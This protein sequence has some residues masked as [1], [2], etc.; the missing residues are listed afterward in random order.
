MLKMR[1]KIEN[2]GMSLIEVIVSMLVLSIAV[3]TVMSAFSMASKTNLQSKRH[4]D[5]ESVMES[6]LE[7][8]EAGGTDYQ[9]AFDVA[10]TDYSVSV[11][12]AVKEETLNNIKQ[13]F[14][15]YNVTVT[16]DTAPAKYSSGEFN[17]HDVIHFGGTGH[18]TV[19]IDAS[20][21]QN[22]S[23]PHN[24][25]SDA[26]D[27]A[28]EYF[29]LWHSQAV[30]EFNEANEDVEDFVDMP[31][32]PISN[33]GSRIGRELRIMTTE[34]EPNKMQLMASFVYTIDDGVKLPDSLSR[35]YSVLIYLSPVYDAGYVTTEGANKLEQVYIMYSDAAVEN[36]DIGLFGERTDIRIVDTAEITP[37]KK[38]LHATIFLV[39]QEEVGES[40]TV[41]NASG[42]ENFADRV[43]DKHEVL[44]VSFKDPIT[45]NSAT[46]KAKIY[47]SINANLIGGD[48]NVTYSAAE[49]AFNL[50]EKGNEVRVVTVTV[51]VEDADTGTVIDTKTITR[52]Q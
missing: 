48:A 17:N 1:E 23:F 8:A 19:L 26:D 25:I 28:Q 21:E 30:D 40:K 46:P 35:T 18:N 4:Q 43:H 15:T 45:G 13:G 5:V 11:T 12:G 29:W 36:H 47:S 37:D 51:A 6:F 44:N 9:S 20:L 52:L 31:T 27:T 22:D 32:I 10:A 49:N 2:R 14:G 38:R 39:N 42:I 7:Y 41:N 34:P 24:N 16:T 33:I 3:V 50:V